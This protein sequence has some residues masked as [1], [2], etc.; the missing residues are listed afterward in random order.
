M[1][2]FGLRKTPDLS[3]A[4]RQARGAFERD[5]AQI[6]RRAVGQ[7]R[8]FAHSGRFCG[9]KSTKETVKIIAQEAPGVPVV[10]VVT[11]RVLYYQLHTGL[12]VP[13][14]PGVSCALHFFGRFFAKL[15]CRETVALRPKGQR[16]DERSRSLTFLPSWHFPSPEIHHEFLDLQAW[17]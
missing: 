12:P 17:T 5:R 16:A 4:P 13:R 15:G 1:Q 11:T 10:P 3:L 7:N 2:L 14:A 6:Q 9:H 8:P